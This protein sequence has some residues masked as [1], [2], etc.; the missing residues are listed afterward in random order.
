[1]IT[2]GVMMKMTTG[3]KGHALILR[4]FVSSIS[5]RW[6]VKKSISCFLL[7]LLDKRT[8]LYESAREIKSLQQTL[9]EQN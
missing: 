8:S 3:V 4:L 5:R 2:V 6:L 7:K 1:M 9:F